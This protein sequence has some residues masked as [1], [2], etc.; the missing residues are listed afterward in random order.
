LSEKC[1]EISEEWLLVFLYV[2]EGLSQALLFHK[3]MVGLTY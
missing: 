1:A 2:I 3:T